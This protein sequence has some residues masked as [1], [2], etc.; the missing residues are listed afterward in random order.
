MKARKL[1]VVAHPDDELLWGYRYLISDPKSWKVICVCCASDTARV[2]EFETVLATIGVDNYEMWDN[3]NT[4]IGWRLHP[5]IVNRLQSE[6]V[7]YDIVITHNWYGEYGNL[8]HMAVHRAVS[9][10]R[11]DVNVFSQQR[12]NPKGLS[13]DELVSVSYPS[14]R[15][16]I[17]VLQPFHS[18]Y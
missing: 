12:S 11:S 3:E 15:W 8:Q 7:K 14:Q 4:I 10:V 6:V 16:I 2:K 5:T 18:K 13:K 17:R 9:A 1:M